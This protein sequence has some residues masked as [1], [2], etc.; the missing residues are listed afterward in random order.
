VLL[1]AVTVKC[2]STHGCTDMRHLT[3]KEKLTGKSLL[4]TRPSKDI[5]LRLRKTLLF[6]KKGCRYNEMILIK[7]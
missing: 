4:G 7:E 6:S 1:K 5:V 2:H 3:T